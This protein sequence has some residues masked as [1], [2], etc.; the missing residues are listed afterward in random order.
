MDEL[1]YNSINVLRNFIENEDKCELIEKSIYD[2]SLKNS[3][4]QL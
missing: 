2:F 3:S 1:R 4:G